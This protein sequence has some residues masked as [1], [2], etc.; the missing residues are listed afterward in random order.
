MRIEEYRIKIFRVDFFRKKLISKSF[1][2]RHIIGLYANSTVRVPIKPIYRHSMSK[3][4]KKSEYD[5]LKL[6]AIHR[7]HASGS[8]I[9]IPSAEE[10]IV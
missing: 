3:I 5:N 1:L 9:Y 4:Q 7:Y 10:L 6:K 8:N 2:V